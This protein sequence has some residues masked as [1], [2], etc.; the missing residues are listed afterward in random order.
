MAEGWAKYHLKDRANICSAG[1][2]ASGV[3]P[4]AIEV[5]RESGIDIS[6]QTSTALSEV[7]FD[8][9]DMV[10]SLCA[11]GDRHCPR[12]PSRITRI[13]AFIPDPIDAGGTAEDILNVYRASRNQIEEIILDIKE[14]L[15]D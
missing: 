11:S 9:I 7:N 2:I 12:L 6:H 13:Q 5:M 4:F 14:K 3:N 8:Q 10:V 15:H 1:V